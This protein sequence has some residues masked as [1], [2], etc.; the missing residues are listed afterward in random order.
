MAIYF[1]READG[2]RHIQQTSQSR[3]Q[4][5]Q[6]NRAVCSITRELTMESINRVAKFLSVDEKIIVYD[7]IIFVEAKWLSAP[8]Y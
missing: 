4:A 2:P 6:P 7:R 8:L 1:A 3:T 5:I